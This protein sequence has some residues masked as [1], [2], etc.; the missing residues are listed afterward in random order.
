MKLEGKSGRGGD[1]WRGGVEYG[2]YQNTL[3]GCLKL[4]NKKFFKSL[5]EVWE[6]ESY[7]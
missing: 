6:A 4:S 5:A 3:H 2:L 1:H 7:V